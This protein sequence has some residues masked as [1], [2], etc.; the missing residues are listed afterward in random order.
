MLRTIIVALRDTFLK[1]KYHI[2]DFKTPCCFNIQKIQKKAFKYLRLV[3][4]THYPSYN[5]S[6]F[7]AL[8]SFIE[9]KKQSVLLDFRIIEIC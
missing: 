7:F 1:K 8:T 2:V 3:K 5:V 9:N 6:K 4:F